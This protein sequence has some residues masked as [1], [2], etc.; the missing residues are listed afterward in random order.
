MI[1]FSLT[2]CEGGTKEHWPAAVFVGPEHSKVCPKKTTKGQ[3]SPV[4]LEQERLVN[5]LL[6][7]TWTQLVYFEFTGLHEQKYTAYDQYGK[8]IDLVTTNQNIQFT[9]RPPSHVI[10]IDTTH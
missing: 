7:G 3:Y 4:W 10:K 1:N 9:S 2:E 8:N 5:S 6:Y